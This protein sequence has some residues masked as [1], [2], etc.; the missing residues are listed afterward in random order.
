[1]ETILAVLVATSKPGYF[2]LHPIAPEMK[3]TQ[4]KDTLSD[5]AQGQYE[6][7]WTCPQK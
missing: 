4:S 1:M 5:D 6:G 2:L 7:G 3:M